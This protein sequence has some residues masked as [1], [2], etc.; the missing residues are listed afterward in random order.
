MLC[1]LLSNC[2]GWELLSS[3]QRVCFFSLQWLPLWNTGSRHVG[4]VVMAP[5]GSKGQ[6]QDLWCMGL[7]FLSVW[8]LFRS[9]VEPRPPALTAGFCTTEPPKKPE[10]LLL[11]QD[12]DCL[13]MSLLMLF[14]VLCQVPLLSSYRTLTWN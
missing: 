9:G 4:S 1:G 6:T 7:L 10:S 13:E 5:P 8:D 14:V 11:V 3:W 12:T 2:R